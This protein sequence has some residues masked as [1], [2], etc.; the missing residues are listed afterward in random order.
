MKEYMNDMI[1]TLQKLVSFDT[2]EQ[3][4]LPG[5]PFGKGC[6]DALD[7][8]LSLA[9]QWGMTIKNLEGYCGWAEVGAGELFGVLA[10]LDVVPVGE[11]WHYPPFGGVIE[12]GRMYGRGTQ[13]DKG[14]LV[15]CMYALKSLLDEGRTPTKRIRFIV[16]CNEE[17]GWACMDRYLATEEHPTMAIS[18]DGDFPVINCEKGIAHHT[19]RV[20]CPEWLLALESGDRVN[21]VPHK[22][23]A[24]VSRISDV[25]FT[26]ALHHGVRVHKDGM[27]YLLEASGKNA[28]GSTPELGDNALVKLL[29]ALASLDEEF[30][31]LAVG[32]SDYNGKNCNL[33]IRDDAS[34]L[35]S[36]NV[37]FAHIENGEVVIGLDIRFPISYT[38]DYIRMALESAF[39]FAKVDSGHQQRS[40]Y[41]APDHPLVCTLLEAYRDVTGMDAKP[42]SIGGGTYARALPTAVAF[43]PVFP[44][45]P[46]MCHQADE[47]VRL[48]RLETMAAIYREALLRLCF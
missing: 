45:D 4:G 46:E 14:P 29:L 3:E 7:Y 23:Y 12:D 43:G 47:Y 33:G 15:A 30:N 48:D 35:L 37:G 36:L 40:L 22:A 26:Y 44:G 32:L 1:A 6:K 27:D 20:P 17:T 25:A 5:A 21:V 38:L 28:H 11:G 31:Q 8:T 2:V 9:E 13:D 19:L 16:G 39:P 18:P 24:K 10:H 34:G 41:I 42:L